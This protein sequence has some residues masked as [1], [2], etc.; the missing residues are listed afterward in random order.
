MVTKPM[1]RVGG[2]GEFFYRIP[3]VNPSHSIFKSFDNYRLFRIPIGHNLSPYR[4]VGGTNKRTNIVNTPFRML[5]VPL[6]FKATGLL[7][8]IINMVIFKFHQLIPHR[9]KILNRLIYISANFTVIFKIFGHYALKPAKVTHGV[10]DG[11]DL[12]SGDGKGNIAH[13]MTSP[14]ARRSPKVFI[15]VERYSLA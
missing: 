15:Q 1:H 6:L 10:V 2:L 7:S 8:N 14:L 3:K 11:G 5:E 4:Y 13:S 12:L 9:S